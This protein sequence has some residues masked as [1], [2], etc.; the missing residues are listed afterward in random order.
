MESLLLRLILGTSGISFIP[1]LF[2]SSSP[3]A[4]GLTFLVIDFIS[5]IRA[6]FLRLAVALLIDVNTFE[7][8]SGTYP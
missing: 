8:G 6:I 2:V 4:R 7:I 5:L 3:L 1:P